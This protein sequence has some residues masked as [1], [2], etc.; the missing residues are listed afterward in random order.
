MA[1]KE[2]KNWFTKV[3][4]MFWHREKR[5][6]VSE[7]ERNS[8]LEAK[9]R[10][11]QTWRNLGN[12]TRS[13]WNEAKISRRVES[14][15]RK[16]LREKEDGRIQE[17][18]ERVYQRNLRVS[19]LCDSEGYSDFVKFLQ[20]CEKIGYAALRHPEFRKGDN[21]QSLDY[22]M[23]FQNGLLS[24]IEDSRKFFDDAIFMVEKATQEN[25]EAQK[26]K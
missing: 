18:K 6:S 26:I 2:N 1:T 7:S 22:Y 20:K 21:Q 13:L 8:E 17:A 23:G 24:M 25:E 19:K 15:L 9:R 5:D 3:R 14:S 12:F 11:H 10:R 4:E 16:R